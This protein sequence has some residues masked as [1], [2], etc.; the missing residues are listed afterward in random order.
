MHTDAKRYYAIL[1]VIPES[2]EEAIRTA[3]RR[4]AKE[5]HPDSVSGSTGAFIRLKRAYD[6]LSVPASR[7]EYDHDC[8]KQ[9]RPVQPA[10]NPLPPPPR[11]A[12]RR[13]GVGFVRYATAFV[14]MGA[15]SF[16]FIQAMISWTEA[17]PSRPAL[18]AAPERAGPRPSPSTEA[19]DDRA[20]NSAASSRAP[21]SAGPSEAADTR[22]GFWTGEPPA[23]SAD[24]AGARRRQPA[25]RLGA[26]PSRW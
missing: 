3:F 15:L 21:N 2:S 24:A 13:G 22:P 8:M 1:G 11:P 26:S 10:P 18:Y 17:P 19:S 23:G 9:P 6:T 7:A 14:F 25:D 5:L 16:G 12:R 20:P 4:R